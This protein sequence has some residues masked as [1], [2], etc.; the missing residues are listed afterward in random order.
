MIGYDLNL[1]SVII[2]HL[3]HRAYYNISHTKSWRPVTLRLYQR[4]CQIVF[5]TYANMVIGIF[6]GSLYAEYSCVRYRNK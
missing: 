1:L 4:I 2:F 6:T 5:I 3:G